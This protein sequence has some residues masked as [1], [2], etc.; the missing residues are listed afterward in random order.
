MTGNIFI[1]AVWVFMIVYACIH[2]CYEVGTFLV[3]RFSVYHHRD[4]VILL[5]TSGVET[6]EMDIRM[7]IK[8]SEDLGCSLLIVDSGLSTEEQMI[9]FRL[10]DPYH[11]IVLATMEDALEQ[12]RAADAVNAAL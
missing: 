9:L 6:L 7:A 12:I 8:R 1:D 10:T 11:H 3:E 4:F 5:L 2:I